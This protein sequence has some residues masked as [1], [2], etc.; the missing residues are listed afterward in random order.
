MVN[1]FQ[2]GR[3][4]TRAQPSSSTQKKP[5]WTLFTLVYCYSWPLINTALFSPSLRRS[6]YFPDGG[7]VLFFD[8]DFVFLFFVRNSFRFVSRQPAKITAIT[9]DDDPTL[10]RRLP[11]F[12]NQIIRTEEDEGCANSSKS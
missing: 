4:A 5:K 7:E 1:S 8:F 12:A 2:D 9:V 3:Q 6:V 10:V 11:K